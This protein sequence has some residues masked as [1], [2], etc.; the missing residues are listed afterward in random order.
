MVS[1][2]LGALLAIAS[3]AWAWSG[4][5]TYFAGMGLAAFAGLVLTPL[6]LLP[7]D[8]LRHPRRAYL[9]G[10]SARARR[11]RRH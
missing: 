1:G 5:T 7:M 9:E 8:I 2:A 4:S 3:S 11:Q 10:A 6:V